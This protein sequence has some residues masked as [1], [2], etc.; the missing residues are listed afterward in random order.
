M[1]GRKFFCD[2][3]E[4][5]FA[6]S[7]HIPGHNFYRRLRQP[8]D[9]LIPTCTPLLEDGGCLMAPAQSPFRKTSVYAS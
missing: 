3:K 4:L 5:F 9:L 1:Q 6:L 8:P 2:E 7:V